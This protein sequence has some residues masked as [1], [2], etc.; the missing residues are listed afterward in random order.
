MFTM[1][2]MIEN[3]LIH[4][5]YIHTEYALTTIHIKCAFSQYTFIGGLKPVESELHHHVN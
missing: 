4:V 3:K 1:L 5:V 2:I